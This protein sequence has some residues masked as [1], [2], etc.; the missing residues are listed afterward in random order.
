MTELVLSSSKMYF[1]YGQ[2]LVY[3]QS[4]Q[5]PG[6]DWTDDHFDQGFAR[7]ESVACIRAMDDFGYAEVSV[8]AGMYIPDAA[9]KRVIAVP[10]FVESGLVIVEGPEEMNTGRQISMSPGSYRLVVAQKPLG[11]EAEEIALYF[12]P[13]RQPALCSEIL[14]Q[15]EELN[16]R[17]PLVETAHIAGES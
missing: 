1:S 6:C 17:L 8:W 5:L 11:E 2:F 14:V 3:D 10:F 9:H 15:D 7:R 16:P 13:L 12:E 4:V